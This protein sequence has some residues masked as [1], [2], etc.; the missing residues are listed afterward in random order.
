MARR[1]ILGLL[2]AFGS[3]TMLRG[4]GFLGYSSYRFKMT[5][6][7]ETPN[8]LK[9]GSSVYDV[10]AFRTSD[11]LTGGGS[12]DS[13]LRGE[14]LAVELPDGKTLFA[15]LKTV[16]TPG[17]DD[18]AYMSMRSLDPAF[19][20]NRA[21]SAKRI[22]SGNGI[23]S[24]AEVAPSDYPMLVTFKNMADPTSVEPVQS[25]DLAANFGAGV[26][27]KRIVVEISSGP[28]TVGIEKR[29]GWLSSHR[30]TLK[31]NPPRILD[32]PKDPDLRLL[33]A[34]PF[35]TEIKN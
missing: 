10:R 27:L 1:R 32:D 28:I 4:C 29:L 6:E 33:S 3:A 35:S 19:N 20:Y 7:V 23:Q 13:E 31:A 15:L 2:A 17:H 5:V 22:R 12:S 25:A 24:P 21:E 30:G 14:A 18:L 11:L 16:N 34:I 26:R 9:T 8:G